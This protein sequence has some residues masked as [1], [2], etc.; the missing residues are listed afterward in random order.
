MSR[1]GSDWYAANH[2]VFAC[3]SDRYHFQS[4]CTASN[5]HNHHLRLLQNCEEPPCTLDPNLIFRSSESL[6]SQQAPSILVFCW[7][8]T[9]SLFPKMRNTCLPD[10]ETCRHCFRG[11]TAKLCRALTLLQLYRWWYFRWLRRW[12]DLSW[13][14]CPFWSC[15][16]SSWR[17][18]LLFNGGK[19]RLRTRGMVIV[20][21]GWW[22]NED[23]CLWEWSMPLSPAFLWIIC[24]CPRC[25][26]PKLD[27]DLSSRPHGSL[28]LVL[29]RNS[30]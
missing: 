4:A 28:L 25:N 22:R 23:R 8:P 14:R 19:W 18:L 29:S 12:W 1:A 21:C 5:I 26:G 2:G 9:W 16:S 20:V 11:L 17:C 10:W 13:C 3:C 6:P 24:K 27:P 7:H 30:T 15:H